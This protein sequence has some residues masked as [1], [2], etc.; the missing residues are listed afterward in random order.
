MSKFLQASQ[1]LML[2]A[3]LPAMAQYTA[4]PP[5]AADT[6]PTS[7]APARMEDLR[8]SPRN[9]QS[10]KQQWTDRYECHKWAQGQSGFDPS[11]PGTVAPNEV[12][13]RREQ[14]RRALT[15]CLEGRGYGVQYAAPAPTAAAPAARSTY[16]R[17]FLTPVLPELRYHPLTVQI[18]G[19]YSIAAGSTDRLLDDGAQI[20][21]GLTWFPSASL[22][23]GLRVDGSYSSF[24]ARRELLDMTQP[25]SASFS[26][27]YVNIYG[28]DV[29]LQIDLAHA[30]RSKFYLVG[31]AGWYREQTH[32]RQF[33]IEQGVFCDF[34]S[35]FSGVG[36]VLTGVERTTTPWR[37]SWN[38]GFGLE[39]ALSD[40]A[41]LFVE[42][43]Y[44]RIAPH[45]SRMQFVP[46]TVGLRF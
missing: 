10:E 9:G 36:P 4:T 8:I 7:S 43:R 27:G 30:S 35:C 5:P 20:G 44:R 13:A 11:Q 39:L 15:A 32:L 38:A 19:G 1:A 24:R 26:T 23:V 16:R 2:V 6:P 18:E 29:D 34:F 3:S 25:A 14:Y 41:S 37:S 22:P 31:G 42:G 40:D 45:D 21:L 12:S 33:T 17:P 46:I 28:G